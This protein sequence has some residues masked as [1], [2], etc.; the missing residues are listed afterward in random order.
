MG[1][2]INAGFDFSIDADGKA[3]EVKGEVE[4]FGEKPTIGAILN[5]EGAYVTDLLGVTDKAIGIKFE[6]A[7]NSVVGAGGS[8]LPEGM[9]IASLTGLGDTVINIVTTAIENNINDEAFTK[10]TKDVTVDGVEFKGASVVTFTLDKAMI[11]AIVT[12]I[13]TNITANEDIKALMGEESIDSSEITSQLEGFT[14]IIITSTISAE[15]ETV[16]IDIVIN[17][18]LDGY[19]GFAMKSAF[20]GENRKMS[21]APIDEKGEFIAEEGILNISYTIDGE[22]KE[23]FTIA[24]VDSEETIEYVKAEGTKTN[25][26]H[27]G[28]LTVNADGQAISVKYV[29]EGNLKNGKLILSDLAMTQE[30]VSNEI[31]V[32]LTIEYSLNDTKADLKV[33]VTANIEG[34]ANVDISATLSVETGNVSVT[35][36]A[37]AIDFT[38]ID[39]T[40]A[41]G[42]LTALS[43]KYP[44]I[45]SMISSMGG[46]GTVEPDYDENYD[47]GF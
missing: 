43:E 21:V 24:F 41:M 14:N 36:P 39:E 3:V 5:T 10:E 13:I 4:L 35:A 34:M 11:Q 17:G 32:T 9:D 18:D 8:V 22:G 37:D 38:E 30:G 28:N 27:E 31:P 6:D 23:L 44:S 46:M 7:L 1:K 40:E 47:Y 42:W 33:S 2:P 16:A 25:N 26:K 19:K 45:F 20:V 12:E 15:A 29:L